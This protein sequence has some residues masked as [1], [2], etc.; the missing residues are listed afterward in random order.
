M[1]KDIDTRILQNKSARSTS[2]QCNY[3]TTTQRKVFEEDIK[4]NLYF[5]NVAGKYGGFA[6]STNN[7]TRSTL[8]FSE[9]I[10]ESTSSR[11]V[12]SHSNVDN[13][14]LILVENIFASVAPSRLMKSIVVKTAGQPDAFGKLPHYFRPTPYH[15]D[16]KIL[17]QQVVVETEFAERQNGDVLK[18]VGDIFNSWL[19]LASYLT[20][21]N[22][23]A[24]EDEIPYYIENEL[25]VTSIGAQVVLDDVRLPEEGFYI[26]VNMLSSFHQRSA[27]LE[28]VRIF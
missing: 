10:E 15:L 24:V 4:K 26:L 16:C 2:I 3:N 22:E 21:S 9:F 17:N 11:W 27:K 7:P 23:E 12:F 13:N 19:T 14:L 5:I 25:Q 20:M 18:E 1:R 28:E 8:T 6:G